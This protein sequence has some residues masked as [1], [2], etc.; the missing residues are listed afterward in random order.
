MTLM[1]PTKDDY[2]LAQSITICEYNERNQSNRFTIDFERFDR[3]Q[4]RHTSQQMLTST[5]SRFPAK[6]AD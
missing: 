5:L 1:I 2:M 3:F 4:R 6:L